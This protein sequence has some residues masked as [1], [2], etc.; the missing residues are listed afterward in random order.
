[1]QYSL[2]DTAWGAFGLV[3]RGRRLVATYLPDRKPAILKRI[4]STFPEATESSELLLAFCEQVVRY[5][6][7]ERS[8]FNVAVDLAAYPSFRRAVLEA[9]RRIPYG[10][11]ATYGELACAAGR[12]GAARA[13][14][15]TMANNPLPLVVPCHR[16]VR[17][18]GSIGGFSSPEGVRQK[19]Q[20]LL[21]ED[22][23]LFSTPPRPT[24]EVRGLR[25]TRRAG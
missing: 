6:E 10:R 16:V 17:S 25:R 21:L 12:P 18:D 13:V 11:T 15:S 9:C 14:G 2:V 3:A 4:R 23:T 20:M 24:A 5:F 8:R 22:V 7:G 19:Q 1:M